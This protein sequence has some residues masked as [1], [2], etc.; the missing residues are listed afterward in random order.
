M[1]QYLPILIVGWIGVAYVLFRRLPGPVAA[2]AVVIAGQMFLPELVAEPTTENA[3]PALALPIVKFTKA[4]T[5]GYALLFGSLAVDWRRWGS[6]R[7]RWFDLPMAAWCICPLFPPVVR[8]IGPFAGLYEGGNQVLTQTLLWGVPYWCGRLYLGSWDGLRTAAAAIVLGGIIYAPLCL[9][10]LRISPQLHHWI[11]GYH[12][13]EFAQTKRD[14]GYRPMVFM[15]HGLMVGF[16]MAAAAL[17]A[18]WLW[19]ERTF[20]VVGLHRSLPAIGLGWVALGLATLLLFMHSMGAVVLGI[21]GAAALLG[22]QI[23]ALV[24]AGIFAG[25]AAAGLCR[26]PLHRGVGRA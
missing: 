24:R 19:R 1:T 26:R 11:Y 9:L 10:E 18:F 7:P 16:W 22:R 5:I 8:D 4:N 14:G 6:V 2:L 20:R 15:A 25:P 17:T 12:Q 21:A 3:P 23:S 13:H